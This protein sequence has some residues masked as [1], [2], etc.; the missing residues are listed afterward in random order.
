MVKV[1]GRFIQAKGRKPRTVIIGAGMSGILMGYQLLEAGLDDFTL[2]EK[3]TSFGGTWRENTYP[4]LHCDVKSHHYCYSFGLNPEWS[5]EFPAQ[6]EIYDYFN[7]KA[8][9]FGLEAHVRFNTEVAEARWDGAQWQITL[10]DG[11]TDSADILVSATGFLHQINVPDI[12]GLDSFKGASFHTARWDHSVSLEDKRIGVIG[13]GS[14]AVQ[15][16]SALAGKVKH[17]SLFQRTPQWVLHVPN[18][19]YTPEQ[20]EAF[21]ENPELMQA[22]YD[23]TENATR[24]LSAGIMFPDSPDRQQLLDNAKENLERVANPDLRARLTPDYALGCK[25]LIMSPDF[26]EAIQRPNTELVDEGID[27]VVPEGILTK[28]GRVV[29]LDVIV[30]ATGFDAAAYVRPVKLY[31]EDG[32]SLDDVWAKRPVAYQTITVPHMP[33]FFMIGGPYSPV[34]NISL[35]RV[36]ELQSGWIMDCINK[37]VSDGVTLAPT[38][39][40]T[41]AMVD[42]FREQAKK[43][44][45]YVGGCSSWYLDDEGVPGIYPYP[46]DKFKDDTSAGPDFSCFEV[47][48]LQEAAGA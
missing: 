47:S 16:T 40:A 23:E 28:A 33:N 39:E 13:T 2:Y 26:Y 45:W 11:S 29:E 1:S 19:P 15:I 32:I 21:R 14:T 38:E 7:R 37:I 12:P 42:D 4:G 41:Q 20:R 30:L 6:P 9:E 24:F 48:P 5:K 8:Q 18:E 44:T 43:T 22:I 31:G 10:K 27:R 36:S 34:G 17:F 3:G 35:V 25:R 46:S